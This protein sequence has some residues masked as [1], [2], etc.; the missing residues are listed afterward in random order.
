MPERVWCI[1]QCPLFS[2]LSEEDLSYLERRAKVRTFSRGSPVYFP[3][4]SAD[5]VF[6]LVEGRVRI[7]SV[8]IQGKQAVLALIEPGELFGEMALVGPE[9]REEHAEAALKSKIVSISRQSVEEILLKNAGLSLAVTKFIGMRRQRLERRLRNLLFRSN[10][11]RLIGLL[12]ELIEQYGRTVREGI[13]IDIRLSHQELAGLI[14]VT[15]ESVTLALG[16]LQ[17]EHLI[18]T[19]RKR[20]VVLNPQKLAVE[21]GEK[22]RLNRL[23]TVESPEPRAAPLW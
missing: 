9:A 14:G 16:E 10:R 22:T 3:T 12:L 2:Q 7:Y 8:T 1:K 23:D 4:D 17:L 11:E 6:V 20:I 19:G 18:T 13:L 21:T 5:C 15:R